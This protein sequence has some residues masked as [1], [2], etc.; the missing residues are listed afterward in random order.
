MYKHMFIP[1]SF[2]CNINLNNNITISKQH[3]QI[4]TMAILNNK[5]WF[6]HNQLLL[7]INFQPIKIKEIY[8]LQ[9]SINLIY[10]INGNL[11]SNLTQSIM[12]RFHHFL[13]IKE[14]ISQ[15]YIILTR[16]NLML[17]ICPLIIHSNK[18]QHKIYYKLKVYKVFLRSQ[19]VFNKC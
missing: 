15:I 5:I 12:N 13:L 7:N 2:L 6:N 10:L 11:N 8:H 16:N 14:L 17:I 4:V 19:R 18:W 3:I 9:P 1:L